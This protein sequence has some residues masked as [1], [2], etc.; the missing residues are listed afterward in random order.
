MVAF[1]GEGIGPCATGPAVASNR[2]SAQAER[3]HHWQGPHALPITP[4]A[5]NGVLSGSMPI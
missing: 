5:E 4:T 2:S 1:W 3:F